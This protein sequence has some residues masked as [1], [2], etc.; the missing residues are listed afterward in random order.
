MLKP[1][2]INTYDFGGAAKACIRL[3]KGLIQQGI[4]SKL[5]V[6]NKSSRDI[7]YIFKI[8]LNELKSSLIDKIRRRSIQY[9][10][11]IKIYADK[12][13]KFIQNRHPNLEIFSFPFSEFDLTK[14]T[15]YKN[16][17]VINLHWV[18]NFLDYPTF[19]KNNSKPVIWTLHDENPFSGGEH[20]NEEIIGIDANGYPVY[21]RLT[22]QEKEIFNK[23]LEIKKRALEHADNLTI[24]TPS[25]WLATRAKKSELFRKFNVLTIYNGVEQDIYKP[26][27]KKF[28]RE[29][30]K[31]PLDKKIILFAAHRI[32]NF[33]KGFAFLLKAFEFL[34]RNDIF[35]IAVGEIEKN[36]LVNNY[37]INSLGFIRDDKLMSEIYSAAD[38]F[39]LPSLIDNLPNTMLESLM[40]GTPVVAFP[41]GGIPEVIKTG[42]NG[43]LTDKI[44]SKAL[45]Q[46]I[47]YA[48][49]NLNLFNRE[50]ISQQAAKKFSLDFQVQ[51]YIQLYKKILNDE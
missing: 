5:L 6:K 17:N 38:I 43:I 46:A 9:L 8:T 42:F 25:K 7:P 31:L 2:L 26:Y 36:F 10:K 51:N 27:E 47:N 23:N 40:T 34:K 4:E 29:K 11:K 30:F 14:S 24:V 45:A 18:A 39:V 22:K 19:F 33:R 21:R 13:S 49:D 41:V 48:L 12:K 32:N 16:A 50:D 35:L 37:E 1:L 15:L 28:V 20:Y 44:S 3:H